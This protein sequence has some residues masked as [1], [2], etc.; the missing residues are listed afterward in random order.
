MC[1]GISC[2]IPVFCYRKN[3]PP[4]LLTITGSQPS[5]PTVSCVFDH[6]VEVRDPRSFAGDTQCM[7]SRWDF[8]PQ[9]GVLR[10]VRLIFL[11]VAHYSQ[12]V[13]AET[14]TVDRR[15]VSPSLYCGPSLCVSSS[16]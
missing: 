11:T 9:I 13:A 4:C 1:F 8:L 7:V 15:G 12:A 5:E 10:L 2:H 6:G 3:V 14:S 16:S